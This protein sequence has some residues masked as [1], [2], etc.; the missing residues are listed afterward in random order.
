MKKFLIIILSLVLII[1]GNNPVQARKASKEH[2]KNVQVQEEVKSE[3]ESTAEN[4]KSPITDYYP[5]SETVIKNYQDVINKEFNG[6]F[7]IEET[8]S[9]FKFFL[10]RG[11]LEY[12]GNG[13]IRIL[14]QDYSKDEQAMKNIVLLSD[15]VVKKSDYLQPDEPIS[16]IIYR[17]GDIQNNFDNFKNNTKIFI[18]N[19]YN[20]TDEMIGDI[21]PALC[22]GNQLLKSHKPKYFENLVK[23]YTLLKS[24]KNIRRSGISDIIFYIDCND[25]IS[26]KYQILQA[27][28]KSGLYKKQQITD[29]FDSLKEFKQTETE[30]SQD[31]YKFIEEGYFK[32]CRYNRTLTNKVLNDKQAMSDIKKAVDLMKSYNM[33]DSSITDMVSY[34]IN[35]EKNIEET[36]NILT[37]LYDS[38]KTSPKDIK[39]L[40]DYNYYN[41]RL[42]DSYSEYDNRKDIYS[43]FEEVQNTVY[44]KDKQKAFMRE[45][46]SQRRKNKVKE[47]IHD[48]LVITGVGI[49]AIVSAPVWIP[50]AIMLGNSIGQ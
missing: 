20:I 39:D 44:I 47:N 46:T 10:K 28:I 40:F 45:I 23:V 21:Y 19:K 48:T 6:Q 8:A 34:R 49:V 4:Y 37:Y 42:H 3:T 5:Y 1:A 24:D 30:L 33:G 7:D 38:G 25:D 14:L 11:Y 26:Y 22:R 16:Y 27:M 13:A 18:D 50:F 43:V 31:A 32:Y 29:I 2:K 35:Y 12:C 41:H 15:F 9:S 36:C 17:Y